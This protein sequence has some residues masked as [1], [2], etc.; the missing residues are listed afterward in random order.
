MTQT[1]EM[2]L[3]AWGEPRSKTVS[4]YDPQR[5]AAASVGL[6]GIE[7]MKAIADGR[8]APPPIAQLMGFRIRDVE[9]GRVVFEGT[10]D[11]SVYNPIGVVHG[12][13][14]CTLADS[15]IGCAVHTTLDSG[16][17]YTSID[18]AVNYLRPVTV[19]SGTLVATGTVIKPGRRIA[20]GEAQ[21]VDGNGRLVASATGNCFVFSLEGQG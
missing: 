17:A 5:T 18:I 8:L 15:V 12:G 7:F 21:I 2:S 13:L 11:E 6:S 14:V 1:D 16:I 3:D 4:W 20:T 10:P 19:T 9:P